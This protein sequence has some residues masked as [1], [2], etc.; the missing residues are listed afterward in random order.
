LNFQQVRLHP[1][2][3][4]ATTKVDLRSKMPPVYDQG[5]L[6]SCTS[7]ALCAA[8]AYAVNQ[9]NGSR[10]F[11]Y[12]NERMIENS[13]SQDSGA[14]LHDGVQALETYGLCTETSWPYVAS[15]FAVK[16]PLTCYRS[17]LSNKVLTAT[18]VPPTLASM[19]AC[20]IAGRPFVLGFL[21]FASFET[22]AVARTG[23]VP[24]PGR[25]DPLL[26]GHAVV[27]CGFDDSK[28]WF[29]VR[30]SWGTGWGDKGY[31][32][33]PYAYFT[34]QAYVSDLWAITSAN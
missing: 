1:A 3:A 34:N 7:N 24:L 12:Y 11:L 33:A 8:F 22:A 32:Y 13:V 26:G 31:F 6:G 21:V 16:P 4:A 14:Y 9:F 10:L 15:Q 25:H 2:T 23:I 20:L 28:Q 19:R 30:N 5:S 29:I 17:A 27:V 18:N